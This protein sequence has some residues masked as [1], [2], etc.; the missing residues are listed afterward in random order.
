MGSAGLNWGNTALVVWVVDEGSC[1]GA[2]KCTVG[3]DFSKDDC[4]DGWACCTIL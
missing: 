1:T 2:D 3:R 4:T